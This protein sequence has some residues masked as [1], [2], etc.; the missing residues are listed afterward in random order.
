M[1]IQQPSLTDGIASLRAATAA[2]AAQSRLHALILACFTRLFARLE[3][4]VLLW[5]SGTLPVPQPRAPSPH[6]PHRSPKRP[7]HTRTQRLAPRGRILAEPRP[8]LPRAAPAARSPHRVHLGAPK[9]PHAVTPSGAI[10]PPAPPHPARAPPRPPPVPSISAADARSWKHVH[11]CFDII[12]K[13]QHQITSIAP[14]RPKMLR[15]PFMP[16]I[17]AHVR[18]HTANGECQP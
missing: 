15:Y 16:G 11:F 13:I 2:Q 3:Q 6:T 10:T 18:S 5:K 14:S 17:G 8:T 7:S 9:R 12:I 1:L 4:L